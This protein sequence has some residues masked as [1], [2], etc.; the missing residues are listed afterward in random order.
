MNVL[1][2]GEFK[3]LFPKVKSWFKSKDITEPVT[4]APQL[5]INE[6][7]IHIAKEYIES[8]PKVSLVTPEERITEAVDEWVGLLMNVVI[9]GAITAEQLGEKLTESQKI[10]LKE[11][12]SRQ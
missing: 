7:A 5:L 12:K 3:A 4:S 6:K 10:V 11:W 2:L 1:S 8:T 9:S